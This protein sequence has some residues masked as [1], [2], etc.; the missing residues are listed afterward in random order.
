MEILNASGAGKTI[1]VYAGTHQGIGNRGLVWPSVN[2]I[3]LQGVT[4][5]NTILDAQITTRHIR[6]DN[7]IGWT[8]KNIRLINGK[9]PSTIGSGDNIGGSIY[10]NLSNANHRLTVDSVVVSAN[11]AYYGGAIGQPGSGISKVYLINSLIANNSAD[12]DGGGFYFGTNILANS[13]VYSNSANNGG[14]FCFGENT[15]TNSSVF[16][17]TSGYGGGFAGG[18]NTLNNSRVYSNSA[19]N[20]GGGFNSGTSTLNNTS[21]QGGGF[22]LG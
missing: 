7:A 15:L 11:Q 12:S 19:V 9:S 18:T 1:Q 4:S 6:Q 17:N 8:I 20:N 22:N 16:G 3:T 2:N 5:A 13:N 21:P 10:V 14:G